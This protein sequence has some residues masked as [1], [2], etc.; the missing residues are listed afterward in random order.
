MTFPSIITSSK[1]SKAN[2]LKV[3]DALKTKVPE[4]TNDEY[5]KENIAILHIYH[6][7]LHFLKKE[8]GEVC[9]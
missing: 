7:D 5:V 8:R 1:L 2:L 4:I 3:N 6:S 9:M